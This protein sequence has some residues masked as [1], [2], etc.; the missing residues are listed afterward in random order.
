MRISIVIPVYNVS[1]FLP[2]CLDSLISQTFRDW[3]CLLLD[4]GSSDGSSD[5]CRAYAERDGRFTV[6]RTENRG[7]YA[8]RNA[9]LE[10]ATGD[11]VYFCD[12]DDIL[13][14]EL[15]AVLASALESTGA[16]FSYVDAVEFQEDGVPLF[17]PPSSVPVLVEDAFPLYSRRRCGLALW[18]CLFRRSSLEGISFAEDIRRGADRLFVYRYLR[19][20]PRMVL[21]D[22]ALYGYRQ[23]GGSIVHTAIG[24]AAVRGYAEVMRRLAADYADDRRLAELR[25]GEFVFMTKYIVR[26]CVQSPG[27]SELPRCREVIGELLSE[28][29][30]R[31]RDFGFR[32]AWRIF[33]FARRLRSR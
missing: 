2:A 17:R 26:E 12:S 28:G 16:E 11:A 25:R 24:E 20:S 23:R 5:I 7:A 22:A 6:R 15:L 31:L 27:S 32:W 30:L 3:T 19:R 33:R 18:H 21:V 13:H 9:G 10:W 29:V 1:R 14:P 4:D 8:A